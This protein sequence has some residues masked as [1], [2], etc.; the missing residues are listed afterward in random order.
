MLFNVKKQQFAHHTEL[1]LSWKHVWQFLRAIQSKQVQSHKN[2][3][4]AFA[5]TWS[6]NMKETRIW[7]KEPVKSQSSI[8]QNYCSRF[9]FFLLPITSPI[10]PVRSSISRSDNAATRTHT[11]SSKCP[12]LLTLNTETEP[13][14]HSSPYN[15]SR[16]IGHRIA[17]TQINRQSIKQELS[18]ATTNDPNN[19]PDL[20]E[21]EPTQAGCLEVELHREERRREGRASARVKWEIWAQRPAKG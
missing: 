13:F 17:D 8:G 11:T 1:D 18:S 5:L 6:H 12:P 21:L 14:N 3:K 15:K 16:T 19:Q 2:Y 7:L 4:L 10:N 9:F 20:E